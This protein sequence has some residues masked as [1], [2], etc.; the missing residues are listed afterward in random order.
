MAYRAWTESSVDQRKLT[1]WRRDGK[2]FFYRNG[3]Q[4]MTVD[5]SPGRPLEVSK[6]KVL[7]ERPYLAGVGS[8]C[9][10]AGPTSANYDVTAD[11]QRFLMI[12]DQS[13]SVECKLLR[14]VSN[15]SSALKGP[16]SVAGFGQSPSPGR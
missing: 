10:M 15:W 11:G 8:S 12:E 14:V 3:N 9:G 2:E 1:S 4:M 7:W 16:V 5:V 6:P 13:K